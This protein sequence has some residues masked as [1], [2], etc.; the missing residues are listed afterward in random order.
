M[1]QL[2][3]LYYAGLLLGFAAAQPREA[4]E[5]DLAAPTPDELRAA[6]AGGEHAAGS[7]ATM[8]TLGKTCL[9]GF[10]SGMAAPGFNEALA[11]AREGS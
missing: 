4:P 10:L 5:T 7:R 6:V 1:R 11:I 9:A 8:F 2:T 3:R